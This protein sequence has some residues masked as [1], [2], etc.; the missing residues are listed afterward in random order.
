MTGWRIIAFACGLAVALAAAW[1]IPRLSAPSDRLGVALALIEEGRANEAAHLLEDPAW[2]G[3]AEYRAGR[4]GR[5]ATQFRRIE[6]VDAFYN[7]GNAY[8]MT[9]D[10]RAAREAYGAVLRLDPEHEDALQNLELVEKAEALAKK[11]E[12]QQRE[13]RRLG[14]A[15]DDN[16]VRG[17]EA[18]ADAEAAANDD[19]SDNAVRGDSNERNE[20]EA[21]SGAAS[22]RGRD[23]PEQSER[24]A[25][26]GVATLRENSD[27]ISENAGGTSAALILR[28]SAQEAEILLRLIEDDP[29]RVL[30]ARLRAM[31]QNRREAEQ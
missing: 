21:A 15:D 3:V 14:A 10:W 12:E 28:E 30:R 5:A 31:H 11:L 9:N 13:T 23:A 6:G 18:S 24:Q 7:L 22:T 27:A 29:A 1:L 8:A 4:F 20:G 16:P 26:G 17:E 25:E 19:P 2:R